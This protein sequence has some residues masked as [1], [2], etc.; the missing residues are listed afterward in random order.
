MSDTDL[1]PMLLWLAIVAAILY[2]AFQNRSDADGDS[3]GVLTTL[4]EFRAAILNSIKSVVRR[5]T[6]NVIAQPKLDGSN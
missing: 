3:D 2:S 1:Y 6:K 4:H 5:S